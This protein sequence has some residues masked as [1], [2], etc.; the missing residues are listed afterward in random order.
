MLKRL[1][2]GIS[3]LNFRKSKRKKKSWKKSLAR[4]TLPTKEQNKIN[5]NFSLENMQVKNSKTFKVLRG[6]QQQQQQQQKT[7][8]P[9]I[10]YPVKLSFNMKTK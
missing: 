10:L 9:R 2:L 6:K 8:Q 1:Y 5:I 4:K 7:H 3:C